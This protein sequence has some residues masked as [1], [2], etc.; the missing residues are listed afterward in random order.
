MQDN[1]DNYKGSIK[2]ESLPTGADETLRPAGRPKDWITC[3][4]ISKQISK[5]SSY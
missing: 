5:L 4:Y 2:N 1:L 3:A